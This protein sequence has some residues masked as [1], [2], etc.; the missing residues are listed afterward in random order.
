MAQGPVVAFFG[1]CTPQSL[2]E[3]KEWVRSNGWT[4]ED[5]RIK[6]SEQEDGYLVIAKRKLF[7]V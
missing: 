6:K 7:N 4:N 1:Y 5:V 2:E 3:C